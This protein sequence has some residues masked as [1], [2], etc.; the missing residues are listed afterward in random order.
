[1]ALVLSSAL[2]PR[3]VMASSVTSDASA[4]A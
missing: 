2:T 3:L 4:P 1:L